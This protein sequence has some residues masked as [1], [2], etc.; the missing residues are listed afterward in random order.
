MTDEVRWTPIYSKLCT[1]TALYF[2]LAAL[3]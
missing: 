1:N 3:C 2:Y